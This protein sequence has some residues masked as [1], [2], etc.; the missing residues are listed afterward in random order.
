MTLFCSFDIQN[1]VF[2]FIRSRSDLFWYEKRKRFSNVEQ[3]G[4]SKNLDQHI[5]EA[6]LHP[7]LQ[8][9]HNKSHQLVD[10]ETFE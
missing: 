2:I 7:I 8:I 6:L 5:K 10:L 4:P 3:S 9:L 1:V